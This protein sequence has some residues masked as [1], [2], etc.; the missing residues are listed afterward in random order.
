MHCDDWAQKARAA[1][2]G[3]NVRCMPDSGMFFGKHPRRHIT[4]PRVNGWEQGFSGSRIRCSPSSLP[5]DYHSDLAWADSI[6]WEGGPGYD[7]NMRWVYQHQE[8]SVDSSCVAHYRNSGV[9]RTIFQRS[10]YSRCAFPVVSEKESCGQDPGKCIFAQYVAPFVDTPVRAMSFLCARARCLTDPER[11]VGQIFALQSM[12]D[13]W[14]LQNVLGRHNFGRDVSRTIS[15]GIWV[16]FFQ[17]C[18]Q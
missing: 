7:V 9:I 14:S 16:A 3:V 1:S 10:R 5:A 2:R 17:E 8:V 13:Q 18:Q 6:N 12:Y 15:A 4:L 11:C